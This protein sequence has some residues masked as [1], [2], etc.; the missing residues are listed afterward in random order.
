GAV[1]FDREGHLLLAL[2]NVKVGTFAFGGN[3]IAG[4]GST[5]TP[6]LSFTNSRDA[7]ARSSMLRARRL[8]AL[9][10]TSPSL[11]SLL[12]ASPP[13]SYHGSSH[14]RPF[15]FR[16]RRPYA[17]RPGRR[18]RIAK[19]CTRCPR[20]QRRSPHTHQR[21]LPQTLWRSLSRSGEQGAARPRLLLR[22]AR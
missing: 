5:S 19:T 21:C 13:R 2:I 22:S 6:M 16:R 18:T 9:S 1:A 4:G 7:L 3:I 17:R 11:R 15:R 20:P 8:S 14:P 10:L 12:T